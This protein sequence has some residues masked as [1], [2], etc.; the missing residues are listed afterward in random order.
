MAEASPELNAHELVEAC[1][2]LWPLFR[3]LH[4]AVLGASQS[5][6]PITRFRCA[7]V[8]WRKPVPRE[9]FQGPTTTLCLV[10]AAV[11][12]VWSGKAA[13]RELL[14]RELVGLLPPKQAPSLTGSS[15]LM[16]LYH[17]DR[18]DFSLME[19]C[20]R[21]VLPERFH[22]PCCPAFGPHKTPAGRHHR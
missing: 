16:V 21:R 1:S 15:P 6:L 3:C 11:D 22:C 9:L 5:R 4:A 12:L 7:Q 18:W 17:S 13:E 8:W 14:N 19:L 2:L 20:S 10:L